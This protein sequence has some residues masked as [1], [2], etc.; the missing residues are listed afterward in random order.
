MVLRNLPHQKAS[1]IFSLWLDHDPVLTNEKAL[2]IES[3]NDHVWH[4]VRDVKCLLEADFDH[5]TIC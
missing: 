2:I 1:R 3:E 5:D 4:L